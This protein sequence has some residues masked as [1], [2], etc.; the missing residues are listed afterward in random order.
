VAPVAQPAPS[1]T[2]QPAPFDVRS[3]WGSCQTGANAVIVD[4]PFV[5]KFSD[6]D[7]WAVGFATGSSVGVQLTDFTGHL[8]QLGSAT[9]DNLCEASGV[10]NTENRGSGAY[11]VVISGTLA[12]GGSG[13][14]SAPVSIVAVTPAPTPL[15]LAA[16]VSTPPAR[17]GGVRA[18]PLNW[19]TIKVDWTDNSM[20][21]Q[22]FRIDSEAGQ[23]RTGPNTQTFNVGGLQPQTIYCFSVFSFNAGGDSL[24]GTSCAITPARPSQ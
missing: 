21:E 22:G 3:L 2:P 7:W 4:R 24:G 16:Q 20:D 9:V 19:N 8:W 17:P 15:G 5:G 23:F 1:Q 12:A 14:V 11:L 13:T 10:I 18:L 6:L